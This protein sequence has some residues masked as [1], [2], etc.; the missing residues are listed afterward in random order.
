ML[1]TGCEYIKISLHTHRTVC[2]RYLSRDMVQEYSVFASE[3]DAFKTVI[4]CLKHGVEGQVCI[5]TL[6]CLKC[7]WLKIMHLSFSVGLMS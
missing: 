3:P 5:T 7:K 2:R 4:K 6:S 1:C